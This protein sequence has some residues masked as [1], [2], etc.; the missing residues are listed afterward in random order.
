MKN[1]RRDQSNPLVFLDITVSGQPVGR[2]LLELFAADVPR[3]RL[4]P[5]RPANR[6]IYQSWPQDRHSRIEE[7]GAQTAENFR[8]LCT[9]EAGTSSSGATL[10]YKGCPFHRIIRDFM[11]QGG[12]FTRQNGTWVHSPDPASRSFCT[13]QST[14][15]HGLG[16][17][18]QRG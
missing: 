12:D 8:Q 10:S 18:L 9:G 16:L 2:I 17:L 6:P 7:L 14:V 5:G 3:V 15:A 13:C 4:P 1:Q 11:C